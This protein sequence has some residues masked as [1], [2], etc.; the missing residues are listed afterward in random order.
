MD[1]V[2]FFGLVH[3]SFIYRVPPSPPLSQ[4]QANEYC[5]L[6]AAAPVRCCWLASLISALQPVLLTQVGLIAGFPEN[7]SLRL[8]AFLGI[9]EGVC[10]VDLVEGFMV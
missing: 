4:P 5:V 10:N 9:E 7:V 8:I 1:L 2:G 6:I 3:P